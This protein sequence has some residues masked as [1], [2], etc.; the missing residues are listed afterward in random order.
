[1]IK[2]RNL[3]NIQKA[4]ITSLV[5]LICIGC[6]AE[7]KSFTGEVPHFAQHAK[8]LP[9]EAQK[10]KEQ[11][12]ITYTFHKLPQA[13]GKVFTSN[14]APEPKTHVFT[15]EEK[16]VLLQIHSLK[17]MN[18]KLNTVNKD[19][20]SLNSTPLPNTPSLM[21]DIEFDTSRLE[22]ELSKLTSN[23]SN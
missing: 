18:D 4:A 11:E 13:K 12:E 20:E 16:R 10:N 15:E 9:V 1:M 7:R 2:A 8:E 14:V 21:K 3:I 19:L 17:T 22:N 6:E 5:A 23:K